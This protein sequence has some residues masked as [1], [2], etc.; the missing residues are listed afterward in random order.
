MPYQKKGYAMF[1]EYGLNNADEL[2]YIN[3][4]TRGK[5]DSIRCPYCGGALLAKKGDIKT[6]HFAHAGETCR[7][8]QRDVDISLP[9]YDNFNL[10]ISTLDFKALTEFNAGENWATRD[11]ERLERLE[12]VKYNPFNRGSHW[13][14]TKLGK[15][16]FGELSLMLFNEVQEPLILQRH[17]QLEE[18]VRRAKGTIDFDVRLGD[19]RIYRAQ[20]RRI[21]QCRLYFLEITLPART[22]HKIGLTTRPIEERAAE[23]A[24]DLRSHFGTVQIKTLGTWEH[25]GNVELYF[26]HRYKEDQYPIGSLTEYFAFEDI[27]PVLRDLRRMK[28]KELTDLEAEIITGQSPQIEAV[29]AAELE[30]ERIVAELRAEQLAAKLEAA[31]LAT[32]LARKKEAQRLATI[33]GMKQAKEA[34]Q[35][36]GRPKGTTLAE[37]KFLAKHQAVVDALKEG[38]SLRQTA[39]RTGVAVNTVRKVK[40]LMGD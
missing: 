4:V 23:I 10:H 36:I 9:M 27:A 14:L 19:L 29:I 11:L 18:A 16:P 13:E 37:D 1:L 32:E 3:Q 25:R 7:A 8:V 34:G 26:K 17:E 40:A 31:R 5:L 39:E 15:I 22:V 28:P 38:L 6:H 33:E 35:H 21:L 2:V 30:A 24:A 20:L 12:L